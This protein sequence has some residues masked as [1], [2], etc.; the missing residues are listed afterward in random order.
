VKPLAFGQHGKLGPGFEQLLLLD[1]L[2]EEGADEAAKPYLIPN[3]VVAKGVQLRPLRQRVVMA[4]QKA[5]ADVLLHRLHYAL[6]G[7]D[8]AAERRDAQDGLRSAAQARAWAGG[9]FDAD[10]ALASTEWGARQI[11]A[12]RAVS[13]GGRRRLCAVRSRRSAPPR[14][15]S[16]NQETLRVCTLKQSQARSSLGSWLSEVLF[17]VVESCQATHHCVRKAPPS[18]GTTSHSQTCGDD[19]EEAAGHATS[20]TTGSEIAAT[21]CVDKPGIIFGI[22]ALEHPVTRVKPSRGIPH[23]GYHSA[24]L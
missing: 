4:A 13:A 3:R 20:Q 15:H 1:Q 23:Q 7:W 16:H 14:A 9:D 24:L 19:A 8:T 18:Q 5:Q 22:V 12:G 2:A 17:N 10:R 6:L 21:R 11:R